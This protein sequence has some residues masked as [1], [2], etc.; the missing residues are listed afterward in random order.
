[1]YH[2]EVKITKLT[3]KEEI[4]KLGEIDCGECSHCCKFEGAYM[5]KDDIKRLSVFLGISEEK[6]KK[7]YLKKIKKFNTEIYRIKS[8]EI[9]KPYGP[10]L[11]YDEDEKCLVHDAKPFYC[12]I[13][14]CKEIG[15]QIV[16]WFHLNYLVNKDDS[17]SVREWATKV[18][19]RPTIP[20]GHIQEIVPDEKKKQKNFVKRDLESF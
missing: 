2:P 19:F 12:K 8:E 5:L 15:S 4:L 14:T 16:D 1:M 6:L 3:P 13:G 11:F 18:K 7:E 20:G 10:C 17:E 9:G